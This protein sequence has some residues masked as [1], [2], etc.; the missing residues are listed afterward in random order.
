ML[1]RRVFHNLH[2]ADPCTKAVSVASQGTLAATMREVRP[3]LFL[4]VPRVWEKIEEKM[5]D[6]G[7]TTGGLKKR[8]ATWAKGI[9]YRGN[10][11]VQR[12]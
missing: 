6:V 12:G 8:I 5:R 1:A 4:G 3:T 9:G 11:S 2:D 7:R 10:I